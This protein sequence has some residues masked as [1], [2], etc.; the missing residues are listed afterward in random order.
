MS[1]I[2][3]IADD[4]I[5]NPPIRVKAISAIL[6]ATLHLIQPIPS[7]RILYA[8]D[9]QEIREHLVENSLVTLR[10]FQVEFLQR[11]GHGIQ[12]SVE[13]LTSSLLGQRGHDQQRRL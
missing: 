5:I 3:L 2:C 9:L 1:D 7:V 13:G 12:S 6:I 11:G 4:P 8:L 10:M